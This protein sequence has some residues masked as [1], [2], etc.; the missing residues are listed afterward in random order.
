MATRPLIAVIVVGLVASWA[1]ADTAPARV[2][3]MSE[4]EINERVAGDVVA[5][6]AD[7]VLGP[8]ASVSGHAVSI[9]GKVHVSPGA[10]VEGRVIAVDSLA[11]LTVD[12]VSGA[13]GRR[14]DLGVKLLVAGGWLVATTLTAFLWPARVRRGASTLREQGFRTVALGLMMALTLVAALI[15]VIGLGPVMG[16]PLAVTIAVVFTAAKVL[17]LAVLGAG[18]GE[19][20]LRSL[21]PGRIV[22]V[23]VDVL[24]GVGVMLMA[25]FV[26]V[27]GGAAW[28]VFVVVALGAAIF[29]VTMAAHHTS[30][31]AAHNHGPLRQ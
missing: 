25:R 1:A 17:G 16:V 31:G 18:I 19:L 8:E 2:A 7:V 5:I 30:A 28:T 21:V 15:A 26:P 24:V 9:F 3:A 22:P 20:L 23:T 14:A 27:V 29:A 11:S 12:R 10:T 13:E 6:G 4:L